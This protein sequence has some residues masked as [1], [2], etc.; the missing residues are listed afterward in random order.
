MSNFFDDLFI[1][2]VAYCSCGP[3]RSSTGCNSVLGNGK[4]TF[5]GCAGSVAMLPVI[6]ELDPTT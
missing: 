3:P 4:Q 6:K 2:L 5:Y 1:P